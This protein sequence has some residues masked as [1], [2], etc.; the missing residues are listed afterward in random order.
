MLQITVP[1][2]E[3]WDEQKQ[4]FSTEKDQTLCLEHS[5]VSISKWESKWNKIFLD[6]KE[7]KSYEETLDYVI[8]VHVLRLYVFGRSLLERR[9]NEARF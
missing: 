9:H 5:L 2:I 1:G 6:N 8:S 3:L 7:P 4:E